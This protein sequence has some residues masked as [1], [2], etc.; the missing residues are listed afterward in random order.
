MASDCTKIS[1]R[2]FLGGAAAA[3]WLPF[4][5]VEF[6]NRKVR[7]PAT[8]DCLVIDLAPNCILRE[9]L[10]GYQ[11]TLRAARKMSFGVGT[12]LAY[13]S[14]T[15]IVPALGSMN[16][17]LARTLRDALGA[18]TRLVLESGAGFFGRVEFAAHQNLLREYFG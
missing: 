18:G 17:A 7:R 15:V 6:E 4:A 11:E 13:P 5:R 3:P 8:F 16:F 10:G 1:R 14:K 2:E 9:S 12:E